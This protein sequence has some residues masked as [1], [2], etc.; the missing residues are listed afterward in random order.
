MS[1]LSNSMIESIDKQELA[2]GAERPV[3][4]TLIK[5]LAREVGFQKIGIVRAETLTEEGLRLQQWLAR[6]FHG[7][8]KWMEREPSQRSDPRQLFSD[9]K[10]IIVVALN[11]FT[12]HQHQIATRGNGDVNS[13][14][15]G[16]VSRY[17]WGDD[18]HEI[19]GEKLRRLLSL[20][21]ERWPDADG[22]VCVDIQPTMDKAWADRKST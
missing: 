8:M 16:K 9:A 12:P 17:A 10:S 5:D 14:A 18:Y 19:V 20:I 6:G 11:Y 2:P 7:E 22:K 3:V 21:K 1:I 13:E 15:T 4:S